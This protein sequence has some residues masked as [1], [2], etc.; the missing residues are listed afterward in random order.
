MNRSETLELYSSKVRILCQKLLTHIARTLG[1]SSN[2]F[3]KMFGEAVQ[4]VRMNYYPPCARSDSVL[5]LSSHS[6]GS[7]IT[8]LQQDMACVGLQVLKN[9][10]W[11]PVKPLPHALVI[12]IGD[13]LEVRSVQL[14]LT[15]FENL[16]CT[17]IN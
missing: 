13:T 6:D 1:I 3:N 11:V 7:A 10:M 16:I 5:G 12:N 14:S 8:V 9:D 4:A 2:T 15:K 17:V